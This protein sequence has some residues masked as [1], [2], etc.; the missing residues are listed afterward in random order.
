T[1]LHEARAASPTRPF[2]RR[3]PDRWTNGAELGARALAAKEHC[4][5]NTVSRRMRVLSRH[6]AA[7]RQP[8]SMCAQ[9]NYCAACYSTTRDERRVRPR[10]KRLV[11]LCRGPIAAVEISICA[12]GRRH[13]GKSE[14]RQA[15]A[16]F[17]RR[18]K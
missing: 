11:S 18:Q 17:C 5:H 10:G 16:I 9:K 2:P 15:L 7:L 3:R 1:A 6:H 13:G 4:K 8:R 14:R 12:E